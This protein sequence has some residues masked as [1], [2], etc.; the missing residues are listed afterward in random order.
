MTLDYVG[1]TF[2]LN[3]NTLVSADKNALLPVTITTPLSEANLEAVLK[4]LE[5]NEGTTLTAAQVEA[6]PAAHIDALFKVLQMQKQLKEPVGTSTCVNLVPGTISASS[7][8]Q[9]GIMTITG[10]S[11]EGVVITLK[12]FVADDANG[13]RIDSASGNLIVGDGEANRQ[14]NDPLW[15][16]YKASSTPAAADGGGGCSMGWTALLFFA[17]VPLMDMRRR[18]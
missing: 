3:T 10:K 9:S 13:A 6:D 18:R 12:F 14:I 11:G 5:V 17:L 1:S 16:T 2:T 15:A 4:Q 8:L 7:A